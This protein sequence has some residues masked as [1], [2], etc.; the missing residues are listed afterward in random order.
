LLKILSLADRIPSVL[1]V[2]CGQSFEMI[3]RS[4]DLIPE[5]VDPL[6]WSVTS[7][8]FLR[9]L[10]PA[11]T[12]HVEV[13]SGRNRSA[14]VMSKY[15][16]RVCC[17]TRNLVPSSGVTSPSRV[18]SPLHTSD[19]GSTSSDDDFLQ[20]CEK[21]AENAAKCSQPWHLYDPN[22]TDLSSFSP[23]GS[24]G[25][26]VADWRYDVP[27]YSSVT[28]VTLLDLLMKYCDEIISNLSNILEMNPAFSDSLEKSRVIFSQLI[29]LLRVT[30]E[31][32]EN[33][34]K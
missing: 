9:Y 27:K 23:I 34:E 29:Q 5:D 33:L 17:G 16:L 24:E 3:M 11:V 20:F 13:L 26:G 28:R 8:I 12:S 19:V 15:L 10:C 6:R 14:L 31:S 4:S 32:E 25:E 30:I 1:C 2:L 21:I 7:M 22:A 18:I